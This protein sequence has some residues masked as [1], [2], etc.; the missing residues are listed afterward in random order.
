MKQ[1]TVVLILTVLLALPV[2][3]GEHEGAATGRR[4][5]HRVITWEAPASGERLQALYQVELADERMVSRVVAET[6]RGR[7]LLL[8]QTLDAPSG[9]RTTLLLD[10]PTG[11]SAALETDVGVDAPTLSAL[12]RAGE[13]VEPGEPVTVRLTL[14]GQD[15]IEADVPVDLPGAMQRRFVEHLVATG[16]VDRVAEAVPE[17]L[18]S[19]LFFLDGSLSPNAMASEPGESDNVAHGLRDVVEV[20]AGALREAGIEVPAE[21]GHPW[22]MEVGRPHKGLEA[23]NPE[24]RALVARFGDV[25]LPVER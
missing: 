12:F 5:S 24:L 11:W 6:P 21:V 20:L 9:L 3:A 19:A 7:H 25:G 23:Q 10:E 22:P 14:P 1:N 18:R 8:R 2:A 4:S 17:E 16:S 15:A 13:E